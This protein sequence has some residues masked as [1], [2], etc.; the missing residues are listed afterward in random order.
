MSIDSKFVIASHSLHLSFVNND[1]VIRSFQVAL[2]FAN[3][4]SLIEEDSVLIQIVKSLLLSESVNL[5]HV[6]LVIVLGELDCLV[7]SEI[8]SENTG[9]YFRSSELLLVHLLSREKS[10]GLHLGNEALFRLSLYVDIRN[11]LVVG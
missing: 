10:S 1:D 2:L 11:K 4:V 8:V 9:L 5:D 6:N 7:Q 3:Q